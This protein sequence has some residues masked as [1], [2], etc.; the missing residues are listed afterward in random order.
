[1]PETLYQC[2]ECGYSTHNEDN[3]YYVNGDPLCSNCRFYCESCCDD[4]HIDQ[5]N[6]YGST[7]LCNDCYE[8]RRDS[9]DEA[10]DSINESDYMPTFQ[11]VKMPWENTL[12]QGVELEIEMKREGVDAN[13]HARLFNKWL[14]ANG[15]DNAIYCKHDGSLEN[16]YEVVSHPHTSQGRHKHLNWY[17]ILK[18]L[19]EN[20][21]DS[22]GFASTGLHIH[23]SKS[24]LTWQDIL[25]LKL[26]FYHNQ[27]FVQKIGGRGHNSYCRFEEMPLDRYKRLFREHGTGYDA[28]YDRYYAINVNTNRRKPTVE[29]RI[30]KGTLKYQDF[31]SRLQFVEAACEWMKE[32][33]VNTLTHP[34]RSKTAFREFVARKNRWVQLGRVIAPR[35]RA[36]KAKKAVTVTPEHILE[37]L[38]I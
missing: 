26:F 9:E 38:W 21:A 5:L 27:E 32:A 3:I 36:A 4:Y 8:N 10:S 24:A 11:M 31:I 12:Y 6:E 1:M 14:K 25:K 16:G 35:K 29:F 22:E 23:V 13:N 28:S 30:F 33:S 15:M 18:Y 2:S 34:K 17:A 19:R 37:T 20:G 7:P